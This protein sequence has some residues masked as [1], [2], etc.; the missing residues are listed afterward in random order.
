MHKTY[1]YA[2]VSSK[3]QHEDRQIIALNSF[4]LTKYLSTIKAARTST[5]L[6]TKNCYASVSPMTLSWSRASID[7]AETT[8]KF[9]SNGASSPKTSAPTSSYLIC[10]FSILIATETLSALLYPT[11]C[12]R[13]CRSLHKLNMTLSVNDKQKVSPHQNLV[14]S[15][16]GDNLCQ[17]PITTTTF[18]HCGKTARFLVVKPPNFLAFLTSPLSARRETTPTTKLAV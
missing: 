10:P 11:S 8:K 14:A 16:S 17:S 13:S 1:G 6:S 2:R 4:A 15:S 5:V 7:S 12:F 3:D 18:L 9:L